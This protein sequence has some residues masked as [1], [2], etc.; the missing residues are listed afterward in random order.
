MGS[1]ETRRIPKHACT[2]R[3]VIVAL[4]AQPPGVNELCVCSLHWCGGLSRDRLAVAAGVVC[5]WWVANCGHR[6]WMTH[7][8]GQDRRKTS[9]R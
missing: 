9:V 5:L 1:K 6:G 8:E 2:G 7:V 3:L 4:S